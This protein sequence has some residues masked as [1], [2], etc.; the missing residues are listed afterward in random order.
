VTPDP[1][2]PAFRRDIAATREPR[3]AEW[4][5]L[6]WSD[7]AEFT[8]RLTAA[9]GRADPTGE[10]AA[11]LVLHA[12]GDLG[13]KAGR[14]LW[15]RLMAE[16]RLGEALDVL[17]TGVPSP[18]KDAVYWRDLA[19]AQAG[20]GLLDEAVRSADAALAH[21][22]SEPLAHLRR[23]LAELKSLEDGLAGASDWEAFRRASALQIRFGL[24]GR[25][26]RTLQMA[27]GR[28]TLDKPQLPAF[29]EL[30]EALLALMPAERV[31][32]FVRATRGLLFKPDDQRELDLFLA[33][34]GEGGA[35]DEIAGPGGAP[36]ARAHVLRFLAMAYMAAGARGAAIARLG[37]L[38]EAPKEWIS[39]TV[40]ARCI[41]A[42]VLERTGFACADGPG[43]R[44]FDVFPFHSE[45]DMLE[46][47]LNEM[48]PFVD[49]FVIV[50]S[51]KTFTGRPKPLA[52]AQN[53]GRYAAFADKILHVVVDEF[54]PYVRN[55]WSREFFQRD[56]GLSAL[57]GRC[58]PDD[59]VIVSD[60]DEIVAR[61]AVEGFDDELA[62][63]K[64]EQSRFFLNYRRILPRERQLGL[65]SIWRARCLKRVGLSYARAALPY[66]PDRLKVLDAGWHFSTVADAAQ[67]GEKMKD[68]SHQ[69]YA[70]M[71]RA[72]FH[73]LFEAIRRGEHEPGW[74][75]VELDDS[76]PAWVLEHRD[77]LERMLL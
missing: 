38:A 42:D 34:A 15:T 7:R 58:A 73:E 17:Q 59:V 22:A 47:R 27:G 74:A 50:E 76:F 51:T 5:Q 25:A 4:S 21:G 2:V 64:M 36:L 44:V 35:L 49:H 24:R 68:V 69:E 6:Y 12:N 57:S 39:R 18:R 54:P 16:D 23:D 9:Q 62:A 65:T 10:I 55:A 56:M 32:D 67:V 46:L 60:V 19:L 29:L 71:D 30:A 37:R 70:F 52:F 8:R 48:A 33:S 40:L 20:L 66:L 31:A 72:H 26:M 11:A 1:V 63:L 77:E 53:Q 14:R 45:L 75:R 43:G 61:R 28:L 13:A 3:F 41:S